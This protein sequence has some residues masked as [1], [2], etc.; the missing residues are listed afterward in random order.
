MLLSNRRLSYAKVTCLN[1][2]PSSPR[3]PKLCHPLNVK[4]ESR[5]FLTGVLFVQSF[6]SLLRSW[7]MRLQR[8]PVPDARLMLLVHIHAPNTTVRCHRRAVDIR[9]GRGTA[10]SGSG[11]HCGLSRWGVRLRSHAFGSD[12]RLLGVAGVARLGADLFIVRKRQ[13]KDNGAAN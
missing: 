5:D 7:G 8:R 9:G 11:R 2:R 3:A 1:R 13:V 6:P 4:E 12:G 10:R